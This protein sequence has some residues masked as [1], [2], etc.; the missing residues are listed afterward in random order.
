MAEKVDQIRQY[1]HLM[2][3]TTTV[4]SQSFLKLY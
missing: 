3:Q 2:T 1:L 4:A